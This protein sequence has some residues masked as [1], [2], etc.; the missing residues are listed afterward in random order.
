MQVPS[1]SPPVSESYLKVL[2]LMFEC[3]PLMQNPG[4][5]PG[6]MFE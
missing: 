2:P 5:G 1:C 3:V 4:V 6:V